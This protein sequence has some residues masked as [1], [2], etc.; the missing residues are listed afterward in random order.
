M[1]SSAASSLTRRRNSLPFI[2]RPGRPA[3]LARKKLDSG[4]PGI[5]TGAWKLRNRPARERLSD[6]TS[7]VDR[8]DG[9]AH[10][11]VAKGGLAGAVGSHQHVGLAG[12]DVKVDVVEDGLLVHG[13]GQTF[14]G[15]QRICAHAVPLCI[16]C[17]HG[18]TK[19]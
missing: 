13:G 1:L 5:S 9:V 15:K 12:G 18:C 11:Q 17:T 19:P 4:T 14:D 6:D 7:V 2:S 8:V 10:E 16:W 3:M